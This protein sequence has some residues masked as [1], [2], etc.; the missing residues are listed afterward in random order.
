M[1]STFYVERWKSGR[2]WAVY[3]PAGELVAVVVYLKGARRIAE[4]LN[5]RGTP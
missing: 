4:L 3:D 5:P 2:H 1:G